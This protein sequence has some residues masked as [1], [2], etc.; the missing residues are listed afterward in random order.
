MTRMREPVVMKL[1]ASCGHLSGV[2]KR[3]LSSVYQHYSLYDCC[4]IALNM[5]RMREPV[6]MR[7]GVHIMPPGVISTAYLRSSSH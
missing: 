5:T 4:G 1:G 7:L 3:F 2:Q 6:V